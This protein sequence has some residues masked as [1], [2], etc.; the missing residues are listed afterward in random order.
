MERFAEDATLVGELRLWMW[1]RAR[2]RSQVIEGKQAEGQKFADYFDATEPLQ[3]LPSH[4]ALALFRGRREGVLRLRVTLGDDAEAASAASA[5]AERRIAERFGVEDRGR[6]ANRFLREAVTATW[7]IKVRAQLDD[8]LEARV[9]E[10]AE[11]E[12]TRVFAR[13][14]RDLLL[15]APAGPRVT[16]GLDPG[17]RTGV[18]VAVI[19]RT[20][21]L[22]DTA[23]IYPHAPRPSPPVD[24]AA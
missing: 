17:L 8:E 19:D 11:A 5:V 10:A 3:T 9:R 16:L 22:V 23:T 6:P 4:R 12:A 24:F 1:N 13:N 2:L 15:A 7:K 20:G 21:R 18:K 14:L